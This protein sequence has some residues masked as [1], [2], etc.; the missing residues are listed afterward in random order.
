M[1]KRAWRSARAHVRTGNAAEAAREYRHLL[2]IT[3]NRAD[4]EQELARG[5]R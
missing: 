4:V 5:A 2:Q 1:S 3:L